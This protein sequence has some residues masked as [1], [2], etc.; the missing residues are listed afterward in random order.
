MYNT[1][2]IQ[3]AGLNTQAKQR[4]SGWYEQIKRVLGAA[5]V[6]LTPLPTADTNTNYTCVRTSLRVR[7]SGGAMQCQNPPILQH[8]PGC[9]TARIVTVF[10]RCKLVL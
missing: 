3:S 7:A 8:S 5:N 6:H 9:I 1:P 4:V 10:L 2:N